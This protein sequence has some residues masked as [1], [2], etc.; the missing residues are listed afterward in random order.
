MLK[1]KIKTSQYSDYAEIKYENLY[2]DP[3]GAFISGTTD[4]KY[5]LTD[6]QNILLSIN[7]N[8]GVEYPI[9]VKNYN[10]KGFVKYPQ[11]FKLDKNYIKIN[12]DE[13]LILYGFRYLDG[14]YYYETTDENNNPLNYIENIDETHYYAVEGQEQYEIDLDNETVTVLTYYWLK[15]NTITINGQDFSTFY[16]ETDDSGIEHMYF[17]LETNGVS[18]KIFVEQLKNFKQVTEF[19]IYKKENTLLTLDYISCT[20]KYPYI[21]YGNNNYFLEYDKDNNYYYAIIDG[22]KFI[23]DDDFAYYEDG[24]NNKRVSISYEWRNVERG[25]YLNIYI[26]NDF[27]KLYKGQEIL[28]SRINETN[29]ILF[30]CDNSYFLIDNNKYYISKKN[31]TIDCVDY[32]GTEY[33]ITYTDFNWGLKTEYKDNEPVLKGK[34]IEYG[35]ITVNNET[36]L[37]IIDKLN[38]EVFI[39]TNNFKIKDINRYEIFK[40]KEYQYITFNDE[41][42]KVYVDY[43]ETYEYVKKTVNGE[44]KYEQKLVKKKRK[45]INLYYK[46]TYYFIIDEIY[47][48]NAFRCHLRDKDFTNNILYDIVENIVDYNIMIDNILFDYK[49]LDKEIFLYGNLE[50]TDDVFTL[51][52][53]LLSFMLP[54]KLDNKVAMNLLQED[55]LEK[56]LVNEEIEKSI[57]PSVDMEKD[58]YYPVYKDFNGEFKPINE[59]RF[60]LH[61]RTRNLSDWSINQLSD[62]DNFKDNDNWF[63][64]DYYYNKFNSN[65]YAYYQPS[66]LMYFLGFNNNDIFNQKDKVKKSF[67]RLLYYDSNDIN[68]QSLLATS[69]IFFDTDKLF[70]IYSKNRIYP[71]TY[72]DINPLDELLSNVKYKFIDVQYEPLYNDKVN[73]NLSFDE[74]KRISSEIKIVENANNKKSSEGFYLHLF[75]EYST[76]MHERSIYLKIEFNH[77]GFG[78]KINFTYPYKT[79]VNGN[80]ELLNLSLNS[81]DLITLKEGYS[82]SELYKKSFIEIKVIYDEKSNHY[83]YYFP[84]WMNAHNEEP[85]IMKFNLYEIKVKDES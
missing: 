69:T 3:N 33:E 2:L 75:K 51:Y 55:I 60:Y 79:D 50:G 4:S 71:N 62:S 63:I 9:Q 56:Q 35:Y 15:D 26:N 80:K 21:R 8:N 77:A 27:Y 53:P 18:E 14:K 83:V 39:K 32:N 30:L 44:V 72:I 1:Y 29:T 6:G 68:N 5:N 78:K 45:Y 46:P 17:W 73:Y 70:G 54:I 16:Y 48:S 37:L 13:D 34:C 24:I 22:L 84:T 76:K 40:L 59:I 64:F 82:L 49:K 81:G 74:N 12:E 31:D 85:N 19:Y 42:I 61:F 52:N 38:K 47:E 36:I 58:I 23:Q 43:F 7:G 65:N 66:D 28:I 20:K 10:Y 67:L 11:K 41:K 25:D 57:N